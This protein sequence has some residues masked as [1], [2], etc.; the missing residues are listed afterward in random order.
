MLNNNKAVVVL[1][2]YNAVR[3][4]RR[5]VDEIPREIV[6]DVI[7]TPMTPAATTPSTWPGRWA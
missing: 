3:T 2:A 1:P 4:L 5:T 7:L 6:D